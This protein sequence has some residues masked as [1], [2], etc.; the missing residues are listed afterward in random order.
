[1]TYLLALPKIE[2]T[3][4]E[5]EKKRKEKEKKIR[6]QNG[7]SHVGLKCHFITLCG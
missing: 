3:R 1:M 6:L 7:L 5:K 2:R 4:K